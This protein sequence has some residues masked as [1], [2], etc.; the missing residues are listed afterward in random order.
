MIVRILSSSAS[1]SGVIYN[2]TKVDRDKGELMTVANFGALQGL[3]NLRPEDY[4]NYLKTVSANNKAVKKPQ[5]HVAISAEGKSY[6]KHA[7]TEIAI[8]WLEKMGYGEQPYLLIYHKD[9]VNNHIHAVSTRIDKQGKKINSGFENIRAVHN[10]NIVL[11]IDEKHNARLDIAK[12]LTYSCST[13]AQFL[14]ILENQGYVLREQGGAIQLIKFGKQQGE[15]ENRKIDERLK[16]SVSD[17]GRKAQIKAQFH[18]YAALYDTRLKPAFI[19]SPGSY[20]QKTGT[21]TSEFAQ[22]LKNK[23][24]LALIFHARDGKPPYGYSVIDHSGKAVYKGGEIMP[25]AELLDAKPQRMD[26]DNDIGHPEIPP[27]RADLSP[28]TTTYYK[29]ILEAA[30]NNYPDLVQGLHHLGL[31][32]NERGER[33]FLEDTGSQTFIPV[34]ELLDEPALNELYRQ[35]YQSE[36]ISE[37]LSR[38]YTA[39]PAPYIAP[40]VDDEA[41]HG[42]KRRRKKT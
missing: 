19:P 39:I 26:F 28:E 1:F 24:G 33:L 6:D 25:L 40:D 10:L 3:Q 38:Q 36:E 27:N 7:L 18:K 8:Q 12:A 41:I 29:A 5:F 20:K 9:T 2:M 21:Y 17:P 34:D 4:K 37:E 42:R 23:L 32:I 15:I 16:K 13:K 11:G 35:F 22:H 30:I 31:N 14:M